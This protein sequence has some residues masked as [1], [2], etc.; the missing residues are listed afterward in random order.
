[1]V[2]VSGDGS[3]PPW[4]FVKWMAWIVIIEH[5][6]VDSIRKVAEFS[7]S[8]TGRRMKTKNEIVL[9]RDEVR[10][11]DAAAMNEL[12]V[13][14][15]ILMENAARGACD[16]LVQHFGI[17]QHQG[18]PTTIVCGP[19]NNGGDGLAIARQLLAIG[20]P[21]DIHLVRG[22]KTLSHDAAENLAILKRAG[23]EVCEL[24]TQEMLDLHLSRL[25]TADVVVDCLLG[26][27]VKGA[28][29]EPFAS[30]IRSINGSAARTLAVDVPS[31]LDCELG[32]AD[33]D[34]IKAVRTVTFVGW[35]RGFLLNSVQQ[36]T[37]EVSVAH[38]GIPE[39]WVRA[40]LV[41]RRA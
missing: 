14:G 18:R 38:I 40:W 36:F 33:G 31:G 34:C 4:Q 28:P 35:K 10:T 21:V 8:K 22:Q 5:Q 27:G 26:T 13:S 41:A 29:Q 24:K 23:V 12:G 3:F 19:G 17:K 39:S 2:S 11:L 20:V 7:E 32:T 30:I 25:T 9:S 15:M 6:I 37:G 16:I 1:M